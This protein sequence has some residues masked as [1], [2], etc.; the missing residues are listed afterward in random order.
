M[1]K[2]KESISKKSRDTPSISSEKKKNDDD[3]IL[4]KEVELPAE[5]NVYGGI[6]RLL[7]DRKA[8]IYLVVGKGKIEELEA[9]IDDRL[10][11]AAEL[12][13]EVI[14]GERVI[15]LSQYILEEILPYSFVRRK[16]KP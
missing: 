12:Q 15:T 11:T 14:I 10:L 3:Y 6:I 13:A 9:I 5:G 1:A 16:K 7:D 8:Q 4:E 2:K